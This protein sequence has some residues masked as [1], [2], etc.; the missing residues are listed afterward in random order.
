[1]RKNRSECSLESASEFAGHTTREEKRSSQVLK[2]PFTLSLL[3]RLSPLA[4]FI[5]SLL[6]SASFS[7]S[8]S[9]SCSSYS[10][11]VAHI[12]SHRPPVKNKSLPKCPPQEE[13]WSTQTQEFSE[14]TRNK[15][16][17]LLLCR[18]LLSLSLKIHP[19]DCC[20]TW[21]TAAAARERESRQGQHTRSQ[22]SVRSSSSLDLLSVHLVFSTR[23]V[24]CSSSTN[25]TAACDKLF[26]AP[27]PCPV[28]LGEERAASFPFNG[29]SV[30]VLSELA[31]R[32]RCLLQRWPSQGVLN[33]SLFVCEWTAVR[34]LLSLSSWKWQGHRDIQSNQYLTSHFTSK[35]SDHC[36]ILSNHE[37]PEWRSIF[38]YR[39]IK[40]SWLLAHLICPSYHQQGQTVDFDQRN[41]PSSKFVT[42]I[43]HRLSSCVWERT[44]RES[45]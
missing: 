6:F 20:L 43:T 32:V 5:S 33:L 40:V 19:L 29:S 34:C 36:F 3:S 14:T 21:Q 11:R 45:D 4:S 13:E 42:C 7:S 26:I 27:R 22:Q 31:H 35:Q 8:S 41:Q 28:Q 44:R 18:K 17:L 12:Q 38:V 23:W 30:K 9:S 16:H 1:M 25:S 10:P 24:I 2:L 37:T 15:L 39:E